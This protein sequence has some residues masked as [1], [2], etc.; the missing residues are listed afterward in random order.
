MRDSRIQRDGWRWAW[1]LARPARARPGRHLASGVPL[2]RPEEQ[3]F[4]AM[5][6]GWRNQ[7]LARRLAFSTVESRE[8]AI[9]AFAAHADAFPWAWAP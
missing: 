9:R 8:Q 6:D 1:A 7:Q 4:A 5:L 2:L 3:A